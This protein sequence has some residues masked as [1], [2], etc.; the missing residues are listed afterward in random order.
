MPLVYLPN[1]HE[2]FL[3]GAEP[4][5]GSLQDLTLHGVQGAAQ[6]VAADSRR[7]VAR[8]SRRFDRMRP[9]AVDGRILPLLDTIARLA[10]IP[11]AEVPTELHPGPREGSIDPTR[12]T[13]NR[14]RNAGARHS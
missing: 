1:Q 6:I 14:G 10:V 7:S 11:A 12:T 3:W 13:T 4:A 8:G 2:F 9:Q 5:T